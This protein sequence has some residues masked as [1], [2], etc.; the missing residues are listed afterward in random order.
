[1][2]AHTEAE[3]WDF[4]GYLQRTMREWQLESQVHKMDA[5]GLSHFRSTLEYCQ[6]GFV[7]TRIALA[8][9]GGVRNLACEAHVDRLALECQAQLAAKKAELEGR[10]RQRQTQK[11]NTSQASEPNPTRN[12]APLA[13][14]HIETYLSAL[15]MHGPVSVVI[16]KLPKYPPLIYVEC[17]RATTL[18]VRQ[19]TL[20]P[21]LLGELML[22]AKPIL[23]DPSQ[24]SIKFEIPQGAK[25]EEVLKLIVWWWEQ[26]S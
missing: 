2:L 3:Y 7:R 26:S 22:L 19:H 13:L 14:A 18:E 5:L 9:M 12:L 11:D 21:R 6:K 8:R 15:A 16:E 20:S 23:N 4:M 25:P 10:H 24:T 17:E 1:V